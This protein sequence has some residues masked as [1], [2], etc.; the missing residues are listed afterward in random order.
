M[1]VYQFVVTSLGIKRMHVIYFLV[2]AEN[3]RLTLID[4]LFHFNMSKR[5]SL[6]S[7]ISVGD[8]VQTLY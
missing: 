2:I 4:K 1:V 8:L 6:R 3:S 7:E 5:Y